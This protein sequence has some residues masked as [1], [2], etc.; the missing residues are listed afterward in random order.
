MKKLLS[1]ILALAVILAAG[2]AG[3]EAALARYSDAELLQLVAMISAEIVRRSGEPF[4]VLPGTYVVGRDLPAG[5]WRIEMRDE[6]G[7]DILE[8]YRNMAAM[9]DSYPIPMQEYRLSHMEGIGTRALGNV[10]LADG[11]V[12]KIGIPVIFSPFLGVGR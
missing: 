5:S 11:M 9:T 6:V 12:V 4:E 7:T 10:T 1:L 2:A 3:A 8:I